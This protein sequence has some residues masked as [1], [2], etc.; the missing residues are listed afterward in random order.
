MR[1]ALSLLLSMTLALNMAVA[2]KL[3]NVEA[4]YLKT[5]PYAPE[6]LNRVLYFFSYTC[7]FCAQYDSQF[8]VW[9]NSFPSNLTLEAVPVVEDKS[10]IIY[11][12]AFYAAKLTEPRKIAIFNSYV[13]YLIQSAGKDPNSYLTYEEAARESGLR[14]TEFKQHWEDPKNMEAIMEAHQ[15]YLHYRP[16]VTPT[17]VIKGQFIT[18]PDRVTGDYGLLFKLATGLL[19]RIHEGTADRD[20]FGEVMKELEAESRTDAQ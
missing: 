4:P 18:D 3:P 20:W 5:E 1:W 17:L 16:R 8:Y 10:S 15:R 12:R 11:G 6:D 19:A 7:P 9:G 2:A 13:Y 14:V